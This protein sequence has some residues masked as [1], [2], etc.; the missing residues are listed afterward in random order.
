L[1]Q[2]SSAMIGT[3]HSFCLQLIK[4]Y[5]YV[6]DIDPDFT[7]MDEWKTEALKNRA[8]K[9]VFERYYSADDP[10]FYELFIKEP[11]LKRNGTLT[12]G[13]KID[14]LTSEYAVKTAQLL[15]RENDPSV[16]DTLF[17]SLV[18]VICK[19]AKTRTTSEYSKNLE[20]IFLT[21]A[22]MEK[23]YSEPLKLC[24]LAAFSNYSV[25][26]FTRLFRLCYQVSPMDYLNQLR[27]DNAVTL[28]KN[29]NLSL[30]EIATLCGFSGSSVFSKVFRNHFGHTPSDHR[31]NILSSQKNTNA[32]ESAAILEY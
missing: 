3:I 4:S 27:L 24:D 6:L 14:T 22:Y 15:E 13:L 17:F 5:F 2:L 8:M 26:H 16:K 1:S 21:T 29:P 12:T 11:E 19:N 23:H 28:L 9:R 10:V 25:R 18:T 7:L 32:L 30:S 31:K 20:R